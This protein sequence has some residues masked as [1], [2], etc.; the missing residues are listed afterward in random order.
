[1]RMLLSALALPLL[2]AAG[3]P[4]LNTQKALP[5]YQQMDYG[6]FLC[7]TYEAKAPKGNVAYRGVAVPFELTTTGEGGGKTKAGVIFDT[8]MLRYMAGWSGGFIKFDGVAFSGAHGANPGPNGTILFSTKPTPGWAKSGDLKDP[9]TADYV[10]DPRN[11]GYGTLPSDWG[12]YKG[13]YRSDAGIVFKYTVGGTEVL[14]M[15]TVEDVG[16]GAN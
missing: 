9:R 14:D 10:K 4:S 5:L 1:M 11:V 16:Q 13:L 8:E 3:A 2:V 12:R 15:P 7:A 6:P